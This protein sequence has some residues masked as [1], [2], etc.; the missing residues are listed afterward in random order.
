MS[1]RQQAI[2]GVFWTAIQ[3]WG[4][5]LLVVIVTLILARLLG[6]QLYGLVAYAAT[7]TAFLTIFQR[8]GTVQSLVQREN[9]EPEHISTAFWLSAASGLLLTV[10]LIAASPLISLTVHKPDLTPVL[11]WLSVTLLIDSLGT[12][13][14][15][16]FRRRMAFRALAVRALAAAVA[17]GVVGIVMALTGCGVWSLVGQRVVSSAAGTLTLWTAGRWRPG[18]ALSRR[19][20]RDLFGFGVF[21]MGTETLATLGRHI[22]PFLIGTFLGDKAVGY[23]DLG[24]K[25]LNTMTQLFTGTVSA[26][27]LPTFSRLQQNAAQLRSA[28]VSAMRI[29]SLLAFPASI[30]AAALS[31]EFILGLMDEKWIPAIPIMQIM[32]LAGVILGLTYFNAPLMMACGKASMAFNLTLLGTLFTVVVFLLTVPWGIVVVAA[33]FVIRIYLFAPFPGVMA[34]RLVNLPFGD[35]LRQHVTPV[36]ASLIMFLAL[37]CL[38]MALSRYVPPMAMLILGVILGVSV[39]G[40]ALLVIDRAR[41]RQIIDYIRTGTRRQAPTPAAP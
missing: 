5:N 23:F 33:G 6:P 17:G 3:N 35:Y 28:F 1:L 8:L 25:L 41:L 34:C 15:A 22:G 7:Y 37:W 27:A 26:V 29:T 12:T 16:V 30:G 9:L 4:H 40:G 13:P 2:Q 19:H 20:F 36:I 24:S 21:A 39:Y 14:Q 10:C 18:W 32:S 11:Q 38:K 31:R